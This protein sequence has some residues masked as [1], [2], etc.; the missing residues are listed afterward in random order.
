MVWSTKK[1]NQ[2]NLVVILDNDLC[3]HGNFK[4]HQPSGPFLGLTSLVK[5]FDN[6]V[7][8]GPW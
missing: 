3:F 1:L 4:L 2:V 6:L 5:E 7:L 8:I